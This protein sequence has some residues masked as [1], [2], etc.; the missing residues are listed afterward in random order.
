[1]VTVN[2]VDV[3]SVL[4][5]PTHFNI[6]IHQESF[7]TQLLKAGGSLNE[8]FIGPWDT[9][10]PTPRINYGPLARGVRVGWRGMQAR[11]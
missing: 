4:A 7:L 5:Q 2:G 6:H 11:R 1:M 3:A 8:F 10:A 9:G